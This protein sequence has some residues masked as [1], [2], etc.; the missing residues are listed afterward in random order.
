MA[1][2]TPILGRG[3]NCRPKVTHVAARYRKCRPKNLKHVSNTPN[4]PACKI[5]ST[6]CLNEAIRLIFSIIG[7]PIA[8]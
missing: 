3:G 4:F 5:N 1:K 7:M 2:A 8:H 6:K